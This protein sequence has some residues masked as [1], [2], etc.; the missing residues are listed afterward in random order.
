MGFL[1]P[2]REYIA[3][4]IH[5]ICALVVKQRVIRVPG[6]PSQYFDMKIRS[7]VMFL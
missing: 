3:K 5:K 7:L 2:K 1:Q 6:T 4:C